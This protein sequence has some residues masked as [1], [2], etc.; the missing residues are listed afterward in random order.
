MERICAARLMVLSIS[1]GFSK[2]GVTPGGGGIAPTGPGG[3][4]EASARAMLANREESEE[5]LFQDR[6]GQG[7]G[8]FGLF[9]GKKSKERSSDRP[10]SK[11]KRP[12]RPSEGAAVGRQFL[13]NSDQVGQRDITEQRGNGA[14]PRVDGIIWDFC[15]CK[16]MLASNRK[17]KDKKGSTTWERR[18]AVISGNLKVGTLPIAGEI[19]APVGEIYRRRLEKD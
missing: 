7:V 8:L 15:Y 3:I 6:L 2:F 1:W 17:S 10:A 13:S 16:Y 4:V 12:G 11:A 5:R 18:D 19:G 14:V 9:R